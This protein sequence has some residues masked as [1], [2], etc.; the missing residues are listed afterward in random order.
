MTQTSTILAELHSPVVDELAQVERLFDEELQSEFPFVNELCLRARSYRGK[1]LR[2]TLLLLTAK[3]CR[4]LVSEHITLAAVVEMVHVAT[5]VH[6]D[7]L[8]EADLRRRR[9]TVNATHGNETAVLLGDFLIS[10]AFH[11]C[12]GLDDQ[13]ASR[14]IGA[15]TNT[16]CEGEMMQIHHRSNVDLTEAEYLEIIRRKTAAL[17]GVCCELGARYSGASAAETE[18]WQQ[19]GVDVGI[20]FQIVDDVLDCTGTASQMGKT[21]GRDMQLG[22]PTLPTIHAVKHGPAPIRSDLRRVLSNGHDAAPADIHRWLAECGSLDYA[23]NTAGRYIARAV[24][25]LAALPD[26]PA[27]EALMGVT[28]FIL[29]RHQ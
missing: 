25:H 4:H 17:T 6:D 14:R 23:R 9:S 27:R 19:F 10:H 15:T 22:K 8:D 3:A 5:L 11:L 20:A 26:T 28:E 13:F 18:A 21:L 7:V 2:P 1:M 29:H 16:V 24:Q 12:S